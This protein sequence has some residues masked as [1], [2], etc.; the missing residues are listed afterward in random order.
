M[1]DNALCS[2]TYGSFGRSTMCG[3]GKSIT[4]TPIYSSKDKVLSL[5]WWKWSH[6]SQPNTKWLAGHPSW[7]GPYWELSV[8]LCCWQIWHSA[9]VLA[10]SDLL[11]RSPCFWAYASSLSLPSWL[12]CSWFHCA[13][14]GMIVEIGRVPMEW[15]I[16]SGCLLNSF[17]TEVTF[18]WTLIRM[19]DT[20]CLFGEFCPYP[21][22]QMSFSPARFFFM[23]LTIC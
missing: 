20:F 13:T 22:P 6:C 18:W 2:T 23:S 12:L 7:M 11:N 19:G 10:R 3:K 1:V 15:L 16:L 17:S 4:R 8:G 5:Q 9:G 14:A 21:L